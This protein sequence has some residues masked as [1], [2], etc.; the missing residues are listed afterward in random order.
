MKERKIVEGWFESAAYDEQ[1][2]INRRSDGRRCSRFYLEPLFP[3]WMDGLSVAGKI[4]R[5]WRNDEKIFTI[6]LLILSTR[7]SFRI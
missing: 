2:P 7:L 3:G 4:W 6:E 1:R 5:G